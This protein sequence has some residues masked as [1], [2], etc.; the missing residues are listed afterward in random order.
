MYLDEGKI[1]ETTE[2]YLPWIG[3]IHIADCAARMNLAPA[4]S[5]TEIS[6]LIW[7]G[8]VMNLFVGFELYAKNHTSEAVQA[9][10]ACWE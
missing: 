10:K 8:S 7:I 2:K 6:S 5:I 3:H 9:I 4:S 1:C